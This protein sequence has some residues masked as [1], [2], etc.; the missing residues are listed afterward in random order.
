[1]T[2]RAAAAALAKETTM[3][4]TIRKLAFL[5]ILAWTF[6]GIAGCNTVRGAGEDIEKA[7]DEIQEEA[8]EHD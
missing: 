5:S 8:K 3:N 2:P 4:S 6:A 7:G 1:M